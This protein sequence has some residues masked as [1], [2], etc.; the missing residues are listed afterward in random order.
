VLAI[1]D[2]GRRLT[3]GLVEALCLLLDQRGAHQRQTVVTTNLSRED[4][5]S[6]NPPLASR[7]SAG[8]WLLLGGID[9]RAQA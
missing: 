7:L 2:V 4:L 5:E 8:R 1:D 9:R 3:D 6:A